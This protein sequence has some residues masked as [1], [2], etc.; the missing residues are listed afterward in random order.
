MECLGVVAS[1]GG[2]A[3][4]LDSFFGERNILDTFNAANVVSVQ[5]AMSFDLEAADTS[6]LNETAAIPEKLEIDN[7]QQGTILEEIGR[8]HLALR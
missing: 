8:T 3:L 2:F 5:H 6:C 4:L 7:L 1:H